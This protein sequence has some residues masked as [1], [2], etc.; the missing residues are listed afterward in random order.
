MTHSYDRTQSYLEQ[1][2]KDAKAGNYSLGV[3]LVR[4]AYHPRETITHRSHQS[5]KPS[6]SI[7]SEPLPPVWAEKRENGRM[8]QRVRKDAYREA[9]GGPRKK[10]ADDGNLVR[11]A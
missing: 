10:G 4:G 7:S 8:L 11:D 2:F 1:S 3:K 9:Q 6:L 5:G